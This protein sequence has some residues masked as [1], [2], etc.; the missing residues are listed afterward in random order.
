MI[1][2]RLKEIELLNS[3][4]SKDVI[5]YISRLLSNMK[6]RPMVGDII[7]LRDKNDMDD[8]VLRID[9]IFIGDEGVLYVNFNRLDIRELK[10]G[11]MSGFVCA[12]S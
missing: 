11:L 12:N 1:I 5:K 2:P 6:F 9:G 3:K 8:V 4:S 10:V 7:R